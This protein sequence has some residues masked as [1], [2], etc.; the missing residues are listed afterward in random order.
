M[1][2]VL[3]KMCVTIKQHDANHAILKKI[4]C[5]VYQADQK[6]FH[7]FMNDS[8][9]Q[10]YM[11]KWLRNIC[12]NYQKVMNYQYPGQSKST[13][14][15]SGEEKGEE[16]CITSEFRCFGTENTDPWCKYC[17]CRSIC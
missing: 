11:G 12:F 5:T 17:P 4:W 9:V 14:C 6:N 1:R 10:R 3:K 16:Q 2:I 13:G 7:A 15:L 8:E